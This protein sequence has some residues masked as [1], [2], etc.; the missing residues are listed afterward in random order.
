MKVKIFISEI[1]RVEKKMPTLYKLG[2]FMNRKDE[3][4]LL[5]DCSGLVKGIL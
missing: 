5:C 4:Y 2:T 3:K 1:K